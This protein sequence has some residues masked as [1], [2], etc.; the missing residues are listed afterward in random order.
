MPSGKKLTPCFL[1]L[2][3]FFHSCDIAFYNPFHEYS[4]KKNA[5]AIENQVAT[6]VMNPAGGTYDSARSVEIA[7]GTDEAIIRYTT[8]GTDPNAG[9]AV[10]SAP[11]LI[12]GHDTSVTI[13]AYATKTGITESTIQAEDYTISKANLND[14]LVA[15]W[16]F[17]DNTLDSAGSHDGVL[18]GGGSY[19]TG[20]SGT[21]ILFDG[22][23]DY[24][25][26]P[27]DPC[28]GLNKLTIAAWV[29][30]PGSVPA[31][32][33]VILVHSAMEEDHYG[34]WWNSDSN[35]FHFRATFVGI[36][37]DCKD[38]DT[39]IS[40]DTWCLVA[41]TF[42][43]DT[44]EFICYLNDSVDSTMVSPAEP[45]LSDS[46]IHIGMGINDGNELFQGII[47]EV[48]IYNRVLSE[49]E[50]AELYHLY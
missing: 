33:G 15:L 20:I 44:D 42:N 16:K 22:T 40:P 26:I 36:Q 38:Y 48:H 32:W 14:G 18:Y 17:E 2:L 46:G 43:H 41:G 4:Y 6:P 45:L 3:F 50:I 1:L 9:S 7:C 25:D 27:A 47:D 11:I 8:D 30:F 24:V 39:I 28:F 31:D 23:D 29:Y 13:K 34:L 19:I 35:K 37:E 5:T 10:Y 21:G 12:N 49:T